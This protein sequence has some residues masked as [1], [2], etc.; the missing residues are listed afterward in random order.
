MEQRGPEQTEVGGWHDTTSSLPSPS[1]LPSCDL[2]RVTLWAGVS[3]VTHSA[4]RCH[5][6][7]VKVITPLLLLAAAG[8]TSRQ[9]KPCTVHARHLCSGYRPEPDTADTRPR[10]RERVLAQTRSGTTLARVFLALHPQFLAFWLAKILLVF[11]DICNINCLLPTSCS[12]S[13]ALK[14]RISNDHWFQWTV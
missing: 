9:A 4:P 6:G 7:P 3:L 8:T 11:L 13:E 14:L 12:L 2:C 5:P 1:Q 10:D